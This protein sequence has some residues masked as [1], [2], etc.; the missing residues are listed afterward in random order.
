MACERLCIDYR[1]V[2]SPLLHC[3]RH[4]SEHVKRN[5]VSARY[6]YIVV[7]ADDDDDDSCSPYFVSGSITR[8]Y[9]ARPLQVDGF[10]GIPRAIS[11]ARLLVPWTR[12]GIVKYR[13][14]RVELS[15]SPALGPSAVPIDYASREK[16]FSLSFLVRFPFVGLEGTPRYSIINVSLDPQWV[17]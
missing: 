9:D 7:T 12:R 3:R 17:F 16:F 14:G 4:R 11:T 2:G 10:Y 1:R 6:K 15:F 13:R 5:I 8:A